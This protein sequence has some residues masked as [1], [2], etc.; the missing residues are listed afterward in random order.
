[1]ENEIQQM[2][3]GQCHSRFLTTARLDISWF[4]GEAFGLL[5]IPGL[6]RLAITARGSNGHVSTDGSYK[7]QFPKFA[8]Y[9]FELSQF[10]EIGAAELASIIDNLMK[11]DDL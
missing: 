8:N 2:L 11:C 7:L 3:A 4:D 6:H 5:E 10:F 9:R 1:M